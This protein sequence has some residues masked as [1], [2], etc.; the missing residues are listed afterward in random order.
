MSDRR[1][2]RA[3]VTSLSSVLAQFAIAWQ[4]QEERRRQ[5]EE[6]EG[7]LFKYKEKTHGDERSEKEKEEADFRASYPSF[8]KVS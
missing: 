5:K 3:L 8:E 1:L 6:E 2:E 4:E 7:A